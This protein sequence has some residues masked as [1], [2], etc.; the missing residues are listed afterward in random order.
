[1]KFSEDIRKYNDEMDEY[2]IKHAIYLI[3]HRK[4]VKYN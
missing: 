4:D 3:E 2:T 1:M